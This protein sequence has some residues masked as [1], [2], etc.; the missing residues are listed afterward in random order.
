VD[1]EDR[2]FLFSFVLVLGTLVALAVVFIFLALGLQKASGDTN[3]ANTRLARHLAYERVAP[4]ARVAVAGSAAPMSRAVKAASAYVDGGKV[5]ANI[6]GLMASQGC[7]ACHAVD[8]KIVG[9]AYAWVAYH[10]RGDA[11]AVLYLARKIIKGGAGYWNAWTGGI[12][13][14]AHPQLSLAQ[15]EAMA[16]WVLSQH[17]IA[18]PHP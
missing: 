18:P 2:K 4:V 11:S 15:A 3:Y 9:P 14:P 16:R 5:P 13:M 17:P 8:T 12:A 1:L 10:Y 6:H 7:F